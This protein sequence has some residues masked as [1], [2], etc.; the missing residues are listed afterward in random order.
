M[1]T[2]TAW[3][4][5][6]ALAMAFLFP[7]SAFGGGGPS[8]TGNSQRGA[9]PD[10]GSL[11]K[12]VKPSAKDA[13]KPTTLA[14]VL[15]LLEQKAGVK[16]LA[17]ADVLKAAKPVTLKPGE[18]TAKEI[19]D[20]AAAQAGVEWSLTPDG[21][22]AIKAKRAAETTPPADTKK[23]AE[24]GGAISD[25]DAA[26][27]LPGLVLAHHESE[28]LLVVRIVD[29]SRV[30]KG[31]ALLAKLKPNENLFV[32]ESGRD[33]RAALAFS[34]NSGEFLL[35]TPK[36]RKFR[37]FDVDAYPLIRFTG[38]PERGF[39]A[40]IGSAPKELAGKAACTIGEEYRGGMAPPEP[41]S[42]DS[43]AWANARTW[44]VADD[45]IGRRLAVE[46]P[47][48]GRVNVKAKLADEA[49]DAEG[50]KW[51]RAV[52][53]EKAAAETGPMPPSAP[54]APGMP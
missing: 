38:S 35:G 3:T 19:L 22:V 33:I 20:D 27:I 30:R 23:P 4:A 54:T 49:P 52:S 1:K 48:L 39:T 6:L 47:K 12:K 40:Y 36:K 42:L 26:L 45:E 17:P 37:N 50:R 29:R 53:F 44:Y 31:A 2:K 13:G 34:L 46:A 43:K 18:R 24:D 41:G 9:A 5:A 15:A 21:V 14:K 32:E 10:P 25:A 7:L 51:I 16:Y 8:S 28:R 11:S